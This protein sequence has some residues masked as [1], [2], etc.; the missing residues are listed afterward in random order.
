VAKGASNAS[1]RRLTL[2]V[3]ALDALF[4]SA[5]TIVILLGLGTAVWLIENDPDIPWIM[6][7]QTMGN[8]WFAGHGVSIHV[9]EQALAGIDSPAFDISL[10]PLGLMAVV[11]LFGRRTAR[12]LWGALEFWPGW[13]GA[14]IVYATVSIVLTPIASS[15]TVHPVANE[16]A[17]IPALLY[18]A[19]MVVTNLFGRSQNT[20]VVTRERAWLDDQSARRSQTAN[21]FLASLSK[22]AF[23]AGTAVVVGL[24]AVSAIFLAVSLTF[25]WVSVTRLYEGLQVSLIGGIAVTLA[26]L[27][28]LPNLIIFGASWL[29]G[30]GFSIGAG[31]TVSPFGTEL[32]PIPSIPFF[33]GLPIGENPFGLMVLVVPVLLALAA[34]VLVKPH[35]ADIRFNF[36]SPLSAAI[37]LGLGIGLVAALE[38][39]LLAW[40]ASGGIGPE[41]LAE[42]GV[43]PWMLALVVFVEVAPVSFL[44]AFYSARPD[45]AAPIPEHLKR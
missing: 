39:A 17:A 9:G 21:W 4:I 18:V 29:T 41:R 13:L 5:L 45:K 28:L 38:A 30:L 42:F 31:S 20:E 2:L 27:A 19:S 23:I 33:G 7:L 25:N 14:F 32:G 1:S 24:L 8:L 26:Q 35:A 16:A 22:P 43:N 36:A 10:A 11:Y 44:A 34:T 37:S 40:V 3:G 6:S 12:K 15:Q